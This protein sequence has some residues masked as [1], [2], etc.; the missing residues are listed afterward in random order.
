MINPIVKLANWSTTFS[1]VS[2]A[3]WAPDREICH[4]QYNRQ[5]E[6]HVLTIF[7]LFVL[8]IPKDSTG[9]GPCECC[10]HDGFVAV[11][12]SYGLRKPL[13]STRC[14]L[15]KLCPVENIIITMAN[16]CPGGDCIFSC[17]SL[18]QVSW[19]LYNCHNTRRNTGT[20]EQLSL[21]NARG[22][23]LT[24]CQFWIPVSSTLYFL[25]L[26]HSSVPYWSYSISW[27]F[28]CT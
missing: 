9:A 22:S 15:S 10:I 24:H 12:R 16:K 17:C 26:R 21:I 4:S 14:C 28:S 20:R 23:F 13:G 19:D 6:F 1:W 25:Y 7:L 18:E 5:H 27:W 8:Q 3:S 2:G 11:L